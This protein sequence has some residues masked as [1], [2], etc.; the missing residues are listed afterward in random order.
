MLELKI[1]GYDCWIGEWRKVLAF[2]VQM[3]WTWPI[4][5]CSHQACTWEYNERDIL[6][7]ILFAAVAHDLNSWQYIFSK[8]ALKWCRKRCRLF[9]Y[10]DWDICVRHDTNFQL[11]ICWPVVNQQLFGVEWVEKGNGN[12]IL[13]LMDT[14]RQEYLLTVLYDILVYNHLYS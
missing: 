13:P 4:I 3:W 8:L 11:S 14:H 1:F 12:N 5:N 9:I 7:F 10:I 2:I 6:C